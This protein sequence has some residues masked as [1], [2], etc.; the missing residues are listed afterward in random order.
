MLYAVSANFKLVDWRRLGA[1]YAYIER[2]L[3]LSGLLPPSPCDLL[4]V[5]N[6]CDEPRLA[7]GHALSILKHTLTATDG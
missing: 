5:I 4:Q 2:M 1:S 3:N 7:A 6:V